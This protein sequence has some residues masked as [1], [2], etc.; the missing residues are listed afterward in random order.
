MTLQ[1]GFSQ[2]S[3]EYKAWCDTL[4]KSDKALMTLSQEEFTQLK[5]AKLSRRLKL[6]GQFLKKQANGSNGSENIRIQKPCSINGS[7]GSNGSREEEEEEELDKVWT[8]KISWLPLAEGVLVSQTQVFLTLNKGGEP[9]LEKSLK[10]PT[11]EYKPLKKEQHINKPYEFQSLDEIKSYLDRAKN[12]TL[13]SLY[14]KVRIVV[15]KYV[16]GSEDEINVISADIVFTYFQ[17]KIG[18]THYLMF[19]GDNG[20]GKSNRLEIIGQLGYRPLY[21]ASITPANIYSYLGSV[22]EGQGI[23]L[24]DEADNI[25]TNPEKMKIY[26]VG[27]N[28]GK[29]ISR[30]D[31]THGRVQQ[32]YWTYCFKAFTAEREPDKDTA[33]GFLDRTFVIHCAPGNP[34]Y[35]ISEVIKTGGD[36]KYEDLQ[37]ELADT[38][39][40]LLVY[41]MLHYADPIPNVELSVKNREK[42]LCKPLLRLFQNSECRHAIGSTLAKLLVEKRKLKEN[43]LEAKLYTIVTDLVKDNG[44]A[45]PN[46]IWFRTIKEE[47]DGQDIPGK[48]LSFYSAE[49]GMVSQKRLSDIFTSKFGAETDH[50]GKSRLMVFNANVLER[51][52]VSYELPDKVEILPPNGSNGLYGSVSVAANLEGVNDK[53]VQEIEH[54]S[55]QKSAPKGKKNTPTPP[56]DPLDP[57]VVV[58]CPYCTTAYE[59][60]QEVIDHGVKIHPRKP[61]AAELA[62]RRLTN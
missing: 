56:L 33:K 62:K 8:Q 53:Q 28:S 48:S 34:Q 57:L 3:A 27:Y 59:T 11:T 40:L 21:D 25:D 5:G 49:H 58:P 42:Q 13:D 51:L 24:E 44:L 30:I 6:L 15:S 2:D 37:T 43:T 14:T 32:S 17:D 10:T 4:P 45:L 22:E 50:D 39:K 1:D 38:R 12:Q 18:Q 55:A 19:V 20:T 54:E 26:K 31:L 35:D 29:K 7:N 23:I 46:K 61:I 47:L 16:D 41:R 60:E 52:K 9:V 36:T